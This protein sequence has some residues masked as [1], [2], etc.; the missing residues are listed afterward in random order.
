[1]TNWTEETMSQ[2]IF[3]VQ[4][5]LSKKEAAK[6]YGIPKSTLLG[7]LSSAV[8]KKQDAINRQVL[9]DTQESSLA[10]WAIIQEKLGT[11]PTHRKLRLAAQIML[12]EG[13]N[14]Q[15]LGKHWVTGFLRRNPSIKTY[16]G[17]RLEVK[18]VKGVTP[19]K[20][21]EFDV[22]EGT[23]PQVYSATFTV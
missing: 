10:Q 23:P 18:R 7:R 4:N 6:Q 15:I 21:K 2:A 16:Q 11:P 20:I 22:L 17:K 12:R 5:G 1:M 19:N 9:S 13:G 14:N 8:N 3:A